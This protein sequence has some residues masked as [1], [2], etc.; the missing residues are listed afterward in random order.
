MLKKF[1]FAFI[2]GLL[3]AVTAAAQEVEVERYQINVRLDPA[4]SAADCRAA[5]TVVNL[6]QSPRTKLYFRLTKLAKVTSATINGATAQVESSEDRRVT[7]LNQIVVSTDAGVAPAATAKVEINYRIEAPE[8]SPLIHIY[9][10][11]VLLAPEAI[12]VPMPFS[13]APP[14]IYGPMTAPFTLDTSVASATNNLR[15]LS[16][17]ALKASGATAHVRTAAQFPAPADRRHL[18]P[19][20]DERTPAASTR[21]STRRPAW[22]WSVM[23]K[24]SPPPS[25]NV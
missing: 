1:S 22:S 25:I 14:L 4:A 18:R 11:E 21:K 12:W 16:A 24:P 8:S 20:N 2:V 10:G 13:T 19:A 5:I 3:L 9:P 7:T 15:G 17:G 6:G 23:R